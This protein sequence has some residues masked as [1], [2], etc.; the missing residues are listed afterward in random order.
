MI[1]YVNLMKWFE[2]RGGV[3]LAV[4]LRTKKQGVAQIYDIKLV[5]GS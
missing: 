4:A 2:N 5:M 1:F 3:S